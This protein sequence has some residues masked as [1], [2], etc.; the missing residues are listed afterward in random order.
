[1]KQNVPQE[2]LEEHEVKESLALA[3]AE[4]QQGADSGRAVSELMR[5]AVDG[6]LAKSFLGV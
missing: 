6:S 5:V 2:D 4:E 3:E 1:M